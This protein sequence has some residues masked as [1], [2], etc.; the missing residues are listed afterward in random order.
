MA[1]KSY[2]RHNRV[3]A[4]H[5]TSSLSDDWLTSKSMDLNRLQKRIHFLLIAFSMICSTNI[6]PFHCSITSPMITVNSFLN[7]AHTSLF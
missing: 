6:E 2:G 3:V 1:M 5:G 7:F 4:K